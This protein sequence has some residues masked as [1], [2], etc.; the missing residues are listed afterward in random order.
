[1]SKRDEL[2]GNLDKASA[3]WN[4]GVTF[5]RTNPVPIEKYSVFKTLAD[6]Q[7]YAEE[8]PVAYPGQIITVVPQEGEGNV[9]TYQINND[10]SLKPIGEEPPTMQGAKEEADGTLVD[11]TGGMVPA[12]LK[13]AH[14][15]YLRGSGEWDA[16]NA[17]D[18]Q[19]NETETLLN[20]I[21]IILKQAEFDTLITEKKVTLENGEEIEYDE[22]RIYL[23]KFVKPIDPKSKA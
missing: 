7:K 17:E 3:Y 4:T 2:F 6:A 22:N 14:T 20:F 9:T 11:G 21:P 15:K 16:I 23:I 13:G 1:M 18:V 5:K 12:P 19:I 8:H 10:G